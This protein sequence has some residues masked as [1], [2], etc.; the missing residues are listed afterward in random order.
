MMPE[1]DGDHVRDIKLITTNF[2]RITL[3]KYWAQNNV[4]M[5]DGYKQTRSDYQSYKKKEF[6]VVTYI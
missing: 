4:Q 5:K 3:I 2:K 6:Q 1:L